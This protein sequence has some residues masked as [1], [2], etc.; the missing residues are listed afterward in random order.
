MSARSWISPNEA[1]LYILGIGA[2][3]PE[4]SAF[5]SGQVTKS[6]MDALRA[7]GA[8]GDLLG[9]FINQEGKVVD[10]EFNDRV[11]GLELGSPARPAGHRDCRQAKANW[12]PSREP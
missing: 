8:V 11:L 5:E 2:C 10:C 4:A 3:G 7:A 12:P 1:D 9:R 6:E